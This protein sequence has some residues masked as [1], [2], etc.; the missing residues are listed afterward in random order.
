MTKLRDFLPERGYSVV[1]AYSEGRIIAQVAACEISGDSRLSLRFPKPHRFAVGDR[2]TVHLDNRTGVETLDI[3]LRV[4]RASYRGLVS[5]VRGEFVE[6]E[7]VHYQLFIGT[8]VIAEEKIEGYAFPSDARP[9]SMLP[10]SELSSVIFPDEREAE[11][12][13]GVWI[14]RSEL[15]PH[16]TVMAFLSSEDDDIFLVSHRG[17]FKSSIIHRD[18]RCCFAIDHRSTFLFERAVDW[19]FTVLEAE[20]GLVD[21]DSPLFP[22]IQAQFVRKNPWEEPFFTDPAVELFHLKPLG[23]LCAGGER[24]A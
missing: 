8:H 17:S 2:V 3:N 6:V 22:A 12:K 9:G 4:Y 16:S 13:L 1:S 19:N 10:R 11:N 5:A 23:I 20:A 15:W 24:L 18:R 7:L 21:R 14:T